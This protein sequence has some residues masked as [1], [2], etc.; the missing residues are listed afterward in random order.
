MIDKP[1]F[2]ECVT[3]A[4]KYADEV[5]QDAR[6]PRE[7]IEALQDRRFL[8]PTRTAGA[9][10]LASVGEMSESVRRLSAGC[11]S[12]GMIAAMH[13]TQISSLA[14]YAS[15]NVGLEHLLAEMIRTQGLIASSTTE[16]ATGGDTGRSSCAV[17]VTGDQLAL[18]K[19]ASVISYAKHATVILVTARESVDAAPSDQVLVACEKEHTELSATGVWDALGMRGTD[20]C[21][22]VLTATPPPGAILPASYAAILST[23]M[24]PVTHIMWASVWL[25]IA[26]AI[27]SRVRSKL[28]QSPHA[29]DIQ[30]TQ[31]YDMLSKR[32][33]VESVCNSTLAEY[34]T[35]G[36][37]QP[38]FGSQLRTNA[39]KTIASDHLV[40]IGLAGLAIL[41]MAGYTYGSPLSI[42][43][44]LRDALSAP[45][46]VGNDRIRANSADLAVVTAR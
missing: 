40:D 2:A 37:H 43:R 10:G 42:G 4:E 9:S 20:S 11:S 34:E 35:A 32:Q 6:F 25:G 1:E 15:G 39:L 22:Y 44:P 36:D 46:M 21:G 7:A 23:E 17:E 16:R 19:D 29:A 3:V 45:L 13:Y 26:D 5:D 38:S 8:S 31:F 24:L 41:G 27:I 30:K 14:R 28:R 33:I 18:R 12:T